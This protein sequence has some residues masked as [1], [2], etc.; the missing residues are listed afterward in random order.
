M[1][2]RGLKAAQAEAE[3]ASATASNRCRF[4]VAIAGLEAALRGAECVIHAATHPL[5]SSR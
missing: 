1:R 3:L 4:V 5:R 2:C